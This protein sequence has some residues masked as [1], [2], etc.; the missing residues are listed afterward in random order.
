M[1][2]EPTTHVR[3]GTAQQ[4]DAGLQSYMYKVYHTMGLGLA[5][6]GLTAFGVASIPALFNAIFGTPLAWVAIFAPLGFLW[7]GIRPERQS[8][9][10]LTTMFLIFSM[11]MGVSMAAIFHIFTGASIARVF[12]IT[13]GMFSATS[14]YGYTTRK[15]LTSAG[16]F[17]MMGLIGVVIASLVNIFLQ[18]AMVHFVVSIIGVVVFTG[19]TAWETQRLKYVYQEGAHE[20]NARMAVMGALSLYLNFVNLF[21]IM[22]Q[23]MGD[24]R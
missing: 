5:V 1:S 8:A 18:S 14:L 11:L 7:L 20:A 10:K 13:A 16:S 15:D 3:T 12:F 4:I 22:L 6:T 19:L 24:R 2:Y 23:F 9:E 17:L 21:Q